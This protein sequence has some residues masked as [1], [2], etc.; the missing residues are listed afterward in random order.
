MY[1]FR[2]LTDRPELA[3]D[4]LHQ[5]PHRFALGVGVNMDGSPFPVTPRSRHDDLVVRDLVAPCYDL[6]S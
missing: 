4:R 5:S 2:M 3:G 6:D 1:V